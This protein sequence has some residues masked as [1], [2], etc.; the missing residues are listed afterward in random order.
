MTKLVIL[1]I[2][3][4]FS[5]G[6]AIAKCNSTLAPPAVQKEI[7]ANLD[8]WVGVFSCAIE[9]ETKVLSTELSKSSEF[10]ESGTLIK[11]GVMEIWQVTFC[12]KTRKIKIGF[13]P[14]PSGK[15]VVN[16]FQP[17]APGT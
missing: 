4:L 15:M 3:A 2:L 17:L 11:G 14:G 7:I 13:G 16:W 10:N 5:I 12:A 8:R 6:P 1:V 9:Y